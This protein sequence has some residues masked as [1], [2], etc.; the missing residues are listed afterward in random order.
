MACDLATVQNDANNSGIANLE[1]RRLLV[2]IAQL[3]CRG[4]S[5]SLE[6]VLQDACASGIDCLENNRLLAIIAQL[7]CNGGTP[8]ATCVV[9]HDT[10]PE[11]GVDL[12][13]CDCSLWI[14]GVKHS[15]WFSDDGAT[16]EALIFV[17]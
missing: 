17:P 11:D 3:L 14:N 4:M 2:V 8:G 9:C 16:W 6:T 13:P 10:D 1:T 12:P 15:L 5:C 7:L